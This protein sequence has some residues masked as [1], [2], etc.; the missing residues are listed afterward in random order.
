MENLIRVIR[1]HP[2]ESVLH[3][4]TRSFRMP[5]FRQDGRPA[6]PLKHKGFAVL[7]VRE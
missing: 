7:Q 6:N 4:K 5:H 1:L 3:T 2:G